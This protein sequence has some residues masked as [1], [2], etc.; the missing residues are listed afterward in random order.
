M[1][2]IDNKFKVK[3]GLE[4]SGDATL[5]NNVSVVG[6]LIIATQPN[7]DNSTKAASTAFVKNVV[8]ELVGAAPGALDTLNELATALGGD[9]SFSTTVTTNLA[10]KAPLSSP[11]LTGTPT[12]PT[13]TATTSTTQVA[14]TEFVQNN[15]VSP[16]FT[17]IPVAPTA[18]IDTSTTQLATTAF[19]TNQAASVAPLMNGV[20]NIGTSKRYARQDHVHASDTSKANLAG[21]SF[22]GQVSFADNVTILGTKVIQNTTEDMVIQSVAAGKDIVFKTIGA[23]ERARI[24]ASGALLLGTTVDNGVDTLQVNGTILGTTYKGGAALTGISTAPTPATGTNSTQIATTAYVKAVVAEQA[25]GS[26]PVFSG[27]T[28]FTGGIGTSNNRIMPFVGG[29]AYSAA[30]ASVTGSFK[31]KL[32]VLYND[33]MLKFTLRVYESSS[34]SSFDLVVGGFLA[35]NSTWQNTSAYMVGSVNS[36]VPNVRFGNDGTTCCIWMGDVGDVWSYPQVQVIDVQ[37]GHSGTSSAWM[38]NWSITTVITLDT[39]KIGPIVPN[40]AAGLSSPDLVGTPTAPTAVV[41]TSTTQLATTAF[42]TTAVGTKANTASPALTG[43]PTAPTAAPGT[44]TT[45]LATTA[46]VSTAVAAVVATAPAALD[47]LNE[48]ASAL[49]NDANFATTVSTTLGLKAPLAS[50][51]LTGT[52]TAP[53][54]AVDTNTTQLATTSYV[55]GQGYLKSATA[56]T[57]YAPLASPALSG[58]PTTPTATKGTENTQ[59]ASTQ[60]VQQAINS[61]LTKSIAGGTQV[62]LTASEASNK[63]IILTGAITANLNVILPSVGGNWTIVNNTTGAFTVFIK[64]ASGSAVAIAQ[65]YARSVVS[66]GSNVVSGNSDHTDTYLAGTPTATTA[67]STDNSTRVATTAFV[68]TLVGSIV[69]DGGTF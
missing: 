31:I 35:A 46:F 51:A 30:T 6:D 49:G 2:Q 40:K 60:F 57:T 17:G 23:N 7:T 59:V 47:T 34:N 66:D 28:S 15:K 9:A 8:S 10:A 3:K 48:L 38:S 21:A 68:Q 24:K 27:D 26:N 64:H 67:T 56:S 19:V 33:T 53:T 65:N 50:P 16:A 18:V 4:V 20:A 43:T 25:S 5:L 61:V 36:K 44:S 29:G 54:A 32:P 13:A 22:I 14:T 69:I 41:G 39:I 45:Q 52:P 55:M 11:A 63:V 58:T 62:N 1:T 37:V 42:V 12:A